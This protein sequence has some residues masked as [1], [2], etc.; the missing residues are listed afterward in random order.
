[1]DNITALAFNTIN[2]SPWN[3]DQDTFNYFALCNDNIN[4]YAGSK[5]PNCFMGPTLYDTNTVNKAGK[6]NTAN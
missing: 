6:K 5:E 1:M 2:N 3:A 4:D